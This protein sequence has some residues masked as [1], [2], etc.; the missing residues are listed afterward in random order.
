ML[1]FSGNCVVFIW[2]LL[3]LFPTFAFVRFYRTNVSLKRTVVNN[4][5][6]LFFERYGKQDTKHPQF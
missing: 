1:N 6:R 4:I 5:Y 3:Q 2:T